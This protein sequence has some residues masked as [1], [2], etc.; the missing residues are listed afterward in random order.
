MSHVAKHSRYWNTST[1]V[2]FGCTAWFFSQA[3]VSASM[4]MQMSDIR[5]LIANTFE[6]LIR[7][8]WATLKSR[9]QGT[10]KSCGKKPLA[11]SWILEIFHTSLVNWRT[12]PWPVYCRPL[13]NGAVTGLL[14][15]KLGDPSFGKFLKSNNATSSLWLILMKLWSSGK[16]L[17]SWRQA[18]W[19]IHCFADATAILQQADYVVKTNHKVAANRGWTSLKLGIRVV[20]NW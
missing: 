1:R 13:K 9:S 8:L 3:G 14:S 5:P 16:K 18:P 11:D 17:K 19:L 12:V 4:L 7:G 15:P 10:L 20:I 2:L 6:N